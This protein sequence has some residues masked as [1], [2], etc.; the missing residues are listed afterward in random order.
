MVKSVEAR[1]KKRKKDTTECI[2]EEI[3]PSLGDKRFSCEQEVVI[4][5]FRQ[6]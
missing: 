4:T 2:V 5:G 3:I 6:L 1:E